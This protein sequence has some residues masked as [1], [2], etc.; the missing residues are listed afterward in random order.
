MNQIVY[1]K[2]RKKKKIRTTLSYNPPFFSE[3]AINTPQNT[4]SYFRIK[5]LFIEKIYAKSLFPS[6]LTVIS[7]ASK[8]LE[9]KNKEK[10]IKQRLES[11]YLFQQSLLGDLV[12]PA[13]CPVCTPLVITEEQWRHRKNHLKQ[14]MKKKETLFNL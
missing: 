8:T 12:R 10:S 9:N 4:Q 6:N 11:R 3:F 2:N 5:S 14:K 13:E 1:C 7:S